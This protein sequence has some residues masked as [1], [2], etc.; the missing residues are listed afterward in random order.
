MDEQ[1]LIHRANQV[2]AFYAAE[3]DRSRAR[4][5]VADHLSHFWAPSLRQQLAALVRAGAPELSPLVVESLDGW[6][7]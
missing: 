3:P 7:A 4:F 1:L 5:G 2:A 6:R